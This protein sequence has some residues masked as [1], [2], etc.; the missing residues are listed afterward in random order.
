MWWL[1]LPLS[2]STIL[3]WILCHSIVQQNNQ[4]FASHCIS[5]LC[6][7]S[8]SHIFISIIHNLFQKSC[9]TVSHNGNSNILVLYQQSLPLFRM[10]I[11]A[12]PLRSAAPP[13]VR[14][15]LHLQT[16]AVALASVVAIWLNDF[17]LYRVNITWL[18][19]SRSAA[20]LTEWCLAT[21]G[22]TRHECFHP[23][24]TVGRD[25]DSV[26]SSHSTPIRVQY[27]LYSDSGLFWAI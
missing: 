21:S 27:C 11:C 22:H 15:C 2:S 10:D 5:M 12:L 25:A 7:R 3:P 16:E 4:L 8:T 20:Q 1:M 24:R 17:L 18:S 13:L 6:E 19:R 9:V 26:A 23:S 14:L